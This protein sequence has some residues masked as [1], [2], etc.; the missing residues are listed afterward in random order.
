MHIPNEANTPC[1]PIPNL[2]ADLL[3]CENFGFSMPDKAVHFA[4]GLPR[5][6]GRTPEGMMRL[7]LAFLLILPAWADSMYS[8]IPV[9]GTVTGINNLGQVIGLNSARAVF[10]RGADGSVTT[11]DIP[12]VILRMF[13]PAGYAPWPAVGLGINDQGQIVGNTA[14]GVFVRDTDGS[15]DPVAFPGFATGINN[16]GQITGFSS[17]PDTCGAYAG[18]ICG[19][20]YDMHGGGT[21]AFRALFETWALGINNLGDVAGQTQNVEKAFVRKAGGTTAEFGAGL[22][23]MGAAFD[24][25]DLGQVA[26]A[27][28]TDPA[29]LY[30]YDHSLLNLYAHGLIY[31]TQPTPRV[32]AQLDYPGSDYTFLTGINNSGEVVG[33]YIAPDGR[34]SF[35]AMPVPEPGSFT[36]LIG[37]AAGI[38]YRARRSRQP[39]QRSSPH[40]T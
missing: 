18:G 37:V 24:V 1:L 14:D 23:N 10:V 16:S 5:A 7:A 34:G 33:R 15:V 3:I 2:L 27:V 40:I 13:G 30:N 35:I 4:H 39:S 25:N 22:P 17:S 32:V 12:G 20:V 6:P 26:G 38:A 11:F 28:S 21:T 8:L 29:G 36:L 9:E 31:E 19:V